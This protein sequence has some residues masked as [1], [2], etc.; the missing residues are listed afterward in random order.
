MNYYG[1]YRNIA[2]Y[3]SMW[4]PYFA[5]VG[6]DPFMDGA[7][8]WYPGSGYTFVSA[9]PWGWLPYRYGTWNFIPGNGWMWQP[10]GWSTWVGMPRFAGAAPVQ[11]HGLTPPT[12]TVKTVAVGS[13]GTVISTTL[14]SR[15]VV[16][17]GSAG[18]G[19]PR[20][21]LGNL[22]SLNSEVAKRGFVSLHSA[23]AFST[24]SGREATFSAPHSTASAPAASHSSA[25][26]ASSGSHH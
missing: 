18:I 14:P 6:W 8:S 10:G 5:G 25:S 15:L 26:H 19:V 12:G 17:S 21:S 16:N 9:Y 3:G 23:P 20:G 13:G 7:W 22:R 1:S 2:G 24:S 11:F 4:Q